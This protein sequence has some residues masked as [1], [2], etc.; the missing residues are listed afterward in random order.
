MT[1]VGIIGIALSFAAVPLGLSRISLSRLLF[2]LLLAVLH[3]AASVAY[4]TYTQTHLADATFYYYDAGFFSQSSWTS[5]GTPFVGHIT[6]LLKSGFHAT[7]LD[8]FLMFQ[9]SGF[10]GLMILLRTFSEIHQKVATSETLL[11]F[12]L[13][14]LPSIHF[15]TSAIGKDAPLFFAVSLCTWSLLNPSKR[16]VFLAIAVAVMVL[17]R[18]H[19]ALI[20]AVALAISAAMHGKLSAGR[21]LAILIFVAAALLVLV[22]T[23]Q[24]S[25]NLNIMDPDSVS[26]FLEARQAA[27]TL[28]TGAN[29]FGNAIF[30]VR[31]LSLLFR[32]LFFDAH[33]AMGMIASLENVGSLCLFI[34]LVIRR[35]DVA[36]LSRRVFFVRFVLTFSV[37]LVLLLAAFNYNIGL[38]LRQRV[39]ILPPL[40]S[41][42]VAVWAYR[43]LVKRGRFGL[44]ASVVGT[45]PPSM[46]MSEAAAA[47]RRPAI[48]SPKA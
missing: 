4:Y 5:F 46:R 28:D 2:V 21:K 8:C 26:K 33:S 31:L 1:I 37:L 13:L 32:P 7:Y 36:M 10:C 18:A 39:M 11:P 6:Q 27:E 3:N 24:T 43:Q 42:F 40:F 16:V 15:W 22:T 9:A 34:Y 23:V 20:A 19:I 12:Y 14:L 30:P 48:Q 41:L 29:S 44:P 17:F 38:G 45:W 35:R 25:L 47:A